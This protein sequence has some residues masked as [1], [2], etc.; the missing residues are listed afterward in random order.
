MH[1]PLTQMMRPRLQVLNL[2]KVTCAGEAELDPSPGSQ[3]LFAHIILPVLT[4]AQ[5]LV[6]EGWLTASLP[7]AV[8]AQQGRRPTAG[9]GLGVERSS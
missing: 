8:R 5:A 2:P 7:Q 3:G 1:Y 9:S 4:P 6:P